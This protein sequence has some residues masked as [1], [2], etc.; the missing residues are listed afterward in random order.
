MSIKSG[1]VQL[2]R[3]PAM[4]DRRVVLMLEVRRVESQTLLAVET[5]LSCAAGVS[6]RRLAA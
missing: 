3:A 2:D 5:G 4:L 1:T 6:S